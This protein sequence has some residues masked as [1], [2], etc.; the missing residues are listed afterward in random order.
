M[1]PVVD[2]LIN[3]TSTNPFLPSTIVVASLYKISPSYEVLATQ[4]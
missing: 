1:C 4:L 3:Q 2:E